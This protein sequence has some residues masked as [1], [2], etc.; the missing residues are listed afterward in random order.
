MAGRLAG[1][2]DDRLRRLHASTASICSRCRTRS[3]PRRPSR[4]QPIVLQ[5][6]PARSRTAATERPQRYR[7]AGTT[8][9]AHAGAD[10]V[11]A[12]HRDRRRSVCARRR[13]SAAST[14]SAITATPRRRRG[15]S[16]PRRCAGADAT[17]ARLAARLRL[18]P[19]ACRRSSH[20]RRGETLFAGG[21]DDRRPRAPAVIP[22][23]SREI[24]AGVLAAVPARPRVAPGARVARPHRRPSYEL[25]GGPVSL[26][27]DRRPRR[28]GDGD[29]AGLRLLDQPGGRRQRR[30]H[31]GSRSGAR[32]ARRRTPH[33]DRRRARV[34]ARRSA[35]SRRRRSAPAAARPAVIATARRTV[36]ARRR[37]R[38]RPACS[39]SAATRSACCAASRRHAF[40]GSR[41]ALV[42]ADYR[43]PIARPQRGC[44]H[45]AAVSA[46]AARRGLRRRRPRL[47]GTVP[48]PATSRR[49]LGGELSADIVAGYSLPLTATVGAAW[50]HDGSGAP[51]TARRVYVRVGRAF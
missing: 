3:Q 1:W 9:A 35:S 39:T 42:N 32:S 25:I 41:V 50:G 29:G 21:A 19:L 7:R 46:H 28:L 26:N 37:R 13:R 15:V 44:R 47:D 12:G 45:V 2:A 22:V 14:C 38:R 27:R 48:T 8:A 6:P 51:P 30:G 34:P 11:G 10:I 33:G 4:R 49:S 20:R 43:W 24:E 23:R 18:R 36:P 16:T 40:A 17:T 5:C 31:G